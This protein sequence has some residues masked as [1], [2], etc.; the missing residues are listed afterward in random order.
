MNVQLISRLEPSDPFLAELA[1]LES[2]LPTAEPPWL[3]AIRRR[4]LARFGERGFPGRR[5]ED[6]KYTDVGTLADRP[7]RIAPPGDIKPGHLAT[8]AAGIEA[9]RIEAGRLENNNWGYYRYAGL[10]CLELVFVNGHYVSTSASHAALPDGT[11]VAPLAAMLS[12]APPMLRSSIQ[13]MADAPPDAFAALNAA[14][15][16]DGAYLAVP[17]GVA[18]DVPVHLVFLSAPDDGPV[19]SFPRIYIHLG[20]EA[21]ASVIESYVG[22]DAQENLTCAVTEIIAA[23]GAR[24]DHYR[25]QREH[26]R[27][28]HVGRLSVSQARDSEVTSF[29]IACGA[30]LSRQ[31][32]AVRLEGEGASVAL[33][34]LYVGG[35][36]QHVDHHTR[37]DHLLPHTHSEEHYKGVLDGRSR[38]V[39]NGTV[40]VHPD[41]QKSEAHQSNHN[42]LLS[43]EAEIDTKPE[44]QIHAD[45]V[46]CSHGA[47]VGRLDPDALFYLCSRGIEAPAA[48]AILTQ[49]FIDEVLAHVPIAA[50]RTRLARDLGSAETSTELFSALL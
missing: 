47:S 23:A 10:E 13:R 24:C 8:G 26:P 38:G 44:L 36:R 28:Y 11:T 49:A 46:I 42:L 2:R 20:K 48:R 14:F 32:I 29:S 15:A 16:T 50:V 31:D 17:D 7:L 25:V 33:H 3:R 40:V 9:G 34:G 4:A 1:R 6:W 45:D 43:G 18:L 12:D 22:M 19:A 27:S 35:G 41:A 21:R 30:R 5:D 39:F 37:I